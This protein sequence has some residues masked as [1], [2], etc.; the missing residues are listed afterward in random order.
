VIGN[1]KRLRIKSVS[2]M[3]TLLF[4]FTL[5]TL[6]T[7]CKREQIG[8]I[9]PDYKGP[10]QLM[11][12]GRH[13][14]HYYF[15]TVD[16]LKV[17]SS[18]GDGSMSA[19]TSDEATRNAELALNSEFPDFTG[20]SHRATEQIDIADGHVFQVFFARK[21]IENHY[22]TVSLGSEVQLVFHVYADG[23][24]ELPVRAIP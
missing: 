11:V 4:A 6:F 24:V 16:P 5:I 17:S 13:G 8:L 14:D 9:A 12:Y 3:K 20:Y 15:C 19:V 18:V 23:S 1:G 22:K 10:N 7:S 2:Y 21:V